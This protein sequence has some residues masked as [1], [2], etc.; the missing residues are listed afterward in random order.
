MSCTVGTTH[1]HI[2]VII[3]NHAR[4]LYLMKALLFLGYMLHEICA[5]ILDNSYVSYLVYHKSVH[6]LLSLCMSS[7][8][9]IWSNQFLYE[10][11]FKL[12]C[13]CTFHL[14]YSKTILKVNYTVA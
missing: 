14:S 8:Q 13:L 11:L 3:S 9:S 6:T 10:L 1:K 4:F 7:V 2:N 12:S 5:A